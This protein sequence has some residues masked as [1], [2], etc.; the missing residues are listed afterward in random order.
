MTFRLQRYWLTSLSYLI[1]KNFPTKF[2][3]IFLIFSAHLFSD[4]CDELLSWIKEKESILSGNIHDLDLE[5]V[6]K[7]QR[8]HQ[9]CKFLS[10]LGNNLTRFVIIHLKYLNRNERM[11]Y[12][13]TWLRFQDFERELKPFEKKLQNIKEQAKKW[14]FL[15]IAIEDTIYKPFYC[16]SFK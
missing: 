1:D 5:A 4:S 16:T 12:S 8:K 10:Q 15:T 2:Y 6:R 9:V 11:F 7:L 14:V 13:V 3:K